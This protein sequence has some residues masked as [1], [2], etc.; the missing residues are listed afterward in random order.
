[1]AGAENFEKPEG[2]RRLVYK[3]LLDGDYRKLSATS[4]DSPTGGGAR[5]LRFPYRAFDGVFARL[6][7]RTRE[8]HRRR[9]GRQTV[10]TVRVGDVFL[11]V[12]DEDGNIVTTTAEMTWENATDARK[13]EGRIAR[14]HDSPATHRLLKVRDPSKGRVFVL[15]VQDDNGEVRV[16][17]AYESDLRAGEWAE[18]V[19]R[20]ILNHLD[21]LN[22]R[23]GRAVLGYIDF[24]ENQH[25]GHGLA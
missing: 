12:E 7:P 17:Y 8:E 25:Y 19:A 23:K 16:H 4:N 10:T 2:V 6:L 21:D 15:F 5:D 24:L 22:R 3:E 1:M 9:K 13:S 11:D 18:A 20:P 14:V